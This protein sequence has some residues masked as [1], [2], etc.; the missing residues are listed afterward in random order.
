M[1]YLKNA[2]ELAAKLEVT[3]EILSEDYRTCYFDSKDPA[4]SILKIR[5][6]R[7]RKQFSFDYGQSIARTG[8]K[9]NFYNIFTSL[10]KYDPEDF[11]SFCAEYDYSEDSRQ[12]HKVYTA[13]GKLYTKVANFFTE[14][15]LEELRKIQ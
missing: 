3:M 5:L 7:G 11:E 14:E 6:K 8:E 1:D 10:P 12:A 13:Q 4:R 15:E 9:P 2:E